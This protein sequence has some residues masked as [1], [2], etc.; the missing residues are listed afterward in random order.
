MSAIFDIVL[1][2]GVAVI[3]LGLAFACLQSRCACQH[4]QNERRR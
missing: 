3:I 1:A 4:C 2:I